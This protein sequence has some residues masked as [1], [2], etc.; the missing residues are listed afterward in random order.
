MRHILQSTAAFCIFGLLFLA[1][2]AAQ[3]KG[4]TV[5][6]SPVLG[7]PVGWN[8]ALA[9]GTKQDFV[10][11][12][13]AGKPVLQVGANGLYLT[14]K[15]KVTGE[16]ELQLR[17]R[18]TSPEDKGS[19]LAVMAGLPKMEDPGTNPLRFGLQIHAGAE[20]ENM[21]WSTA[22]LPEQKDGELGNY[23]VPNLPAGRLLWP[24]MVRARVE[25]EVASEPRLT[26]RFITLRYQLL[27]NAYRVYLDDRLLREGRHPKLDATGFVK[28]QFTRGAEI[29][30]LKLI[31]LAPQDPRFETVALEG[32]LNADKFRGQTVTLPK[33]GQTVTVSGVPF[34]LP[35]PDDKAQSHIDLK[36]SWLSCGIVEGA[37]DGWTGDLHRWRGALERNPGR[38]QFR[39]PNAPYAKLHLL[40][41]YSGEPDTTA[42]VS[43]QFFRD[44]A[45]FPV[46]FAS[47]APLFSAASP[48]ALPVPLGKAA[49]AN[50]HLVTIPLEPDGVS[51]S[52]ICNIWNSS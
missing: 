19:Y 35:K 18:M 40:A 31:P 23:T 43:A 15:E 33:P 12:P 16:A 48:N 13:M 52:A 17:F 37:F 39:V 8:V 7:K 38:I 32:Y 26:Q 4:G 14:S 29:A 24:E 45:G 25:Q 10:I 42:I 6:L 41:A 22:P 2:M 49:K 46:N 5:D 20:P 50:L 1:G 28:L 47:K 27:K 36:P 3:D 34:V 9:S 11:T 30:G 51:P 44:S 21:M